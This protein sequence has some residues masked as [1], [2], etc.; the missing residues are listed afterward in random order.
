MLI[1]VYLVFQP[2]KEL[3]ETATDPDRDAEIRIA[4]Y[5]VAIRCAQLEDLQNIVAKIS[6]EQNTQGNKLISLFIFS[7][8]FS[9]WP[10]VI[11][12]REKIYF[13]LSSTGSL[14]FNNFSYSSRFYLESPSESAAV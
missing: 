10:T 12:C 1:I 7:T 9:K 3:L 13:S 5:Q 8:K 2:T 11:G 14:T 4:S 6:G